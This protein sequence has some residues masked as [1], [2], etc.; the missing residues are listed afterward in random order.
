MRANGADSAK[1]IVENDG[2]DDE[3]E[4]HMEKSCLFDLLTHTATLGPNCE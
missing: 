2:D 3:Q 4:E 1:S